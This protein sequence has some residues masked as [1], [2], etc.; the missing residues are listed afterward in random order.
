MPFIAV[1]ALINNSFLRYGIAIGSNE[2]WF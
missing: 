2:I 1:G